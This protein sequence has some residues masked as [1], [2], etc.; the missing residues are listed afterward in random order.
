MPPMAKSKGEGLCRLTAPYSTDIDLLPDTVHANACRG[1]LYESTGSYCMNTSTVW[2]CLHPV[3]TGKQAKIG[4]YRAYISIFLDGDFCVHNL[5]TNCTLCE[6][7]KSALD[8]ARFSG[9]GYSRLP[10]FFGWLGLPDG[11]AYYMEG[12][13]QG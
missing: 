2:L 4:L 12:R 7:E 5:E 11:S 8:L 9:H 1:C 3:A 6:Q 13:W 10:P